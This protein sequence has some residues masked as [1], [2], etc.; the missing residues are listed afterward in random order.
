MPEPFPALLTRKCLVGA[1]QESTSGTPAT[2]SAALANTSVYDAKLEPLDF[3]A[4]GARAPDGHYL[5]EVA[6]V[7]G[8]TLG[9]LTFRQHVRHGDQFLPLLTGAGFKLATGVYAPTSSFADRKTWTLALWEDGR[10]KL[11]YGACADLR[12]EWTNG[13]PLL[14]SWT[15]TGIWSAPTDE[16]MP[17]QAPSTHTTTI[18]RARGATLTLGGAALPMTSRGQ[19]ALGNEVVEREDITAA[20]GVLHMYI[21][22]RRPRITLDP[23]ARSVANGAPFAALLAMTEAALALVFT[24][25]AANTLTIAAPK[26]QRRGVKDGDR[27][28]RRVDEVELGCNA[29]SGDDELTFAASS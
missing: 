19:V 15:W 2:V 4:D 21:A 1:T 29:S 27:G 25:A 5:G 26:A 10:K 22:A 28:G 11:I 14:A 24:D 6:A 16:A 3:F 17:A 13:G 8:K 7:V 9:Q 20:A 12:L 23:E 18:H